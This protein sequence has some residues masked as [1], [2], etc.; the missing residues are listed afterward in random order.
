[1]KEQ[2]LLGTLLGDAS[3]GKLTGKSKSY[4]IK[5]EHCLEQ[6]EYAI[7]K[8]KNSLNNYSIYRR[9]RL[10]SRTNK[11]YNSITCYSRKDNYEYYRN[12]FYNTTK[13]VS[14]EVLDQLQPQAIAVWFM[15]DGNLYYN[16][17]SCHL[18]LSING[19]SEE[20]MN[21]IIEYFRVKYN[22]LFKKAGKAIRLTSIKQVELFERYFKQYYHNS[23]KY[24]TLQFKKEEYDRNM[25][26]ERKK[27]RNTKYK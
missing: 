3:I 10:D 4:I 19:F 24:K 11:I 18:T 27:Y 16:G 23:M 25:S 22:I 2:I 7:W 1:M 14:Q 8:A 21:R 17:N 5:W 15:D 20:S 6:E 13:E 26:S 9:S 12:L